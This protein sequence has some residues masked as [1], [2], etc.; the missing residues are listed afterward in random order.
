MQNQK[1]DFIQGC[2]FFALATFCACFLPAILK[3]FDV[4][5]NFKK[6]SFVVIIIALAS[7]G[8]LNF[9]TIRKYHSKALMVIFL[10]ILITIALKFLP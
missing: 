5:Y 10:G 2:I 8:L 6:E 4:Y 7:I 9:L 1:K 3:Y